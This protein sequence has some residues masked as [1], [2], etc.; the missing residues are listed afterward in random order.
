MM[1]KLEKAMRDSLEAW[2]AHDINRILSFFTDDVVYED[3]PAAKA[4][5]GKAEVRAQISEL[6]AAFPDFMISRKS[7]VVGGG[8]AVTEWVMTGSFK[9][10]MEGMQPTGKSFS[11]RGVTVAEVQ[12]EKVKHQ[13]DYYDAAALMQQIGVAPSAA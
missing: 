4:S 1:A 9:G 11:V 12:G 2:N 5:R 10:P 8:R 13:S 6:F 7:A 3:V